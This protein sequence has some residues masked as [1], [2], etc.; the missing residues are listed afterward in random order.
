MVPLAMKLYGIQIVEMEQ[1]RAFTLPGGASVG[2]I[3]SVKLTK[4]KASLWDDLLGNLVSTGV[5]SSR[6]YLDEVMQGIALS[7]CLSME[8]HGPADS[9]AQISFAMNEFTLNDIITKL[10]LS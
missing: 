2:I 7:K 1:Q 5:R 9:P 6:K 8:I 4:T 3:G 10:W